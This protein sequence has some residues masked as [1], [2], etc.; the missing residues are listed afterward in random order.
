MQKLESKIA[1]FSNMEGP[2]LVD[3]V[4]YDSDTKNT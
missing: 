4:K 2:I 3:L 1:L